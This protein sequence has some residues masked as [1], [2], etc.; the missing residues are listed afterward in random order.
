MNHIRGEAVGSYGRILLAGPIPLVAPCPAACPSHSPACG[1]DDLLHVLMAGQ[2]QEEEGGR[3]QGAVNVRLEEG[4]SRRKGSVGSRGGEGQS[5]R[6]GAVT[7]AWPWISKQ[8]QS[9]SHQNS[10]V[11]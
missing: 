10:R 1:H 9:N 8:Q 3:E 2:H 5:R 7:E 4:S 6:G 11:P